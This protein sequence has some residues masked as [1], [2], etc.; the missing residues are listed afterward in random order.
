MGGVVRYNKET[1]KVINYTSDDKNRLSYN[2]VKDINGD[3]S[4]NIWIAT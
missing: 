2:S 4:G 1:G 3:S